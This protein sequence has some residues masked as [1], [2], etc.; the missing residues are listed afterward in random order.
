MLAGSSKCVKGHEFAEG[1][2]IGVSNITHD[3]KTTTFTAIKELVASGSKSKHLEL[4]LNTS[5]V[6]LQ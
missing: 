6:Y 4:Y 1:T 3:I 5:S 2:Y